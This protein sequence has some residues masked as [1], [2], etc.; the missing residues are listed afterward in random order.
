[1]SSSANVTGSRTCEAAWK[2]L[3]REGAVK[4]RDDEAVH[5]LGSEGWI[6]VEIGRVPPVRD[7]GAYMLA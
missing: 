1:M 6:G 3:W 5:V 2:E 4:V 7:S